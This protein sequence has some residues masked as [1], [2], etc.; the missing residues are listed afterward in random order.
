MSHLQ[1]KGQASMR[2]RHLSWSDQ[3]FSLFDHLEGEAKDETKYYSA[4]EREDPAR[5][6]AMVA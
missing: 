5:I 6:L 4:A 1:E 3:A 2:A